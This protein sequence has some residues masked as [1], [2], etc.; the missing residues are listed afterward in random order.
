MPEAVVT[1]EVCVHPHSASRPIDMA[2]VAIWRVAIPISHS[3]SQGAE[4]MELSG[5]PS[6]T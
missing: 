5:E 3:V 1:L 4:C 6:G 2:R